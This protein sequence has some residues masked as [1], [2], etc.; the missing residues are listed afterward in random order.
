MSFYDKVLEKVKNMNCI[1]KE[2]GA[3]FVLTALLLPIMF[4]C[5][6][7]A[8]D[9]GTVYM[10]KARLQNVA[11]AAALAGGRAYL[12]SQTKPNGKDSVDGTMEYQSKSILDCTYN[13]GRI[14]ADGKDIVYEYKLG[15]QKTVNCNKRGEQGLTKHPDADAAADNYIYNNIVNLGNTV[16]ADRYS[17]FALNYGSADSQI[18]YRI[19]LKETVR[20]RF[21]PVIT[22]K[23][24]ETVRAGAIALVEPGTTT[25]VDGKITIDPTSSFSLFDNL[26]TYSE[27]FHSHHTSD[28]TE[29]TVIT[30]YVGDMVYTHENNA[31]N[32]FF[33]YDGDYNKVSHLYKSSGTISNSQIN[34]AVINTFFDTTAYVQ[35]FRDKLKSPHLVYDER[36]LPSKEHVI[37]TS[38]INDPNSYLYN[39]TAPLVIDGHTVKYRSNDSNYLYLQDGDDYY[40][41]DKATNTYITV[42]EGNT[43]YIICYRALPYH[44]QGYLFKCAKI[45]PNYFLLNQNGGITNIYI[46][47]DK[48]YINKSG[49]DPDPT[50]DSTVGLYNN[51]FQYYNGI[52]QWGPN[53][54]GEVSS[55]DVMGGLFPTEDGQ[56]TCSVQG[57]GNFFNSGNDK[58]YEVSTHQSGNVFYVNRN[59]LQGNVQNIYIEVNQELT[60][61][62]ATP[63]Y[64]IIEDNMENVYITGSSKSRRPIIVAYLGNGELQFNYSGEHFKGTIYAPYASIDPLKMD[65]DGQ[66]FSGSIIARKLDGEKTG[67]NAK[68]EQV[69][70]LSNDMEVKAVSDALKQK[71]Q[72]ASE[73]LTSEFLSD[74]AKKFKDITYQENGTGENVSLSVSADNFGDM[75]WYNNLSYWAKQALYRKWKTI[76]ATETD[77]TKRNLL[78]L[79][80]SVFKKTEGE[81]SSETTAEKLRLINFRTEYRENG[82]PNA[83]VDPFI[84][85]TLGNP[86]AY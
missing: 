35:V 33:D 14:T 86:L 17:H 12:Q 47:G 34:D 41:I 38:E 53:W 58:V 32:R 50:R 37:K 55:S 61:D 70:Y 5:L 44:S 28:N 54:S 65:S 18:F 3:I 81:G 13:K 51:K 69:N 26:F 27:V 82:D 49:G 1:H 77:Q 6:G 85:V 84:Y 40:P 74:L 79:W 60:G 24:S 39:Q 78:W 31:E 71:A 80:S 10:H 16:Y 2:R 52:G 63:I 46:N 11:D 36:N 8:Y 9:V 64:I 56:G 42:Q 30:T 75:N 4:G 67:N 57:N 66:I 19:G 43:G 45:G 15:D 59:N 7:I 72:Q 83:V 62:E 73:S 20:L 23:Y 48:A 25:V 21:L 76:Y 22:N 29:Q 68:F